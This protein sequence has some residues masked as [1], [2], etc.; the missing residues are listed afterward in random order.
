[1]IYLVLTN[2]CQ[3]RGGRIFN[4]VLACTMKNGT[5]YN[6]ITGIRVHGVHTDE[7]STLPNTLK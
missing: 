2:N 5:F 3:C 7:V 1:M 6:A 4:K